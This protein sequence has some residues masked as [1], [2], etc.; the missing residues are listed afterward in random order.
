MSECGGDFGNRVGLLRVKGV[1]DAGKRATRT[2]ANGLVTAELDGTHAGVLAELNCE[3]DFVAKTPLFQET[4]AQIATAATNSKAAARL[5]L[6]SAE[7]KPGATV[8]QLIEQA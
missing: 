4:A 6:L 5:T 2:A 7:T 3:T 8:A 1:K